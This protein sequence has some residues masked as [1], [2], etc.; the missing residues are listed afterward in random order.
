MAS[1]AQDSTGY[2]QHHLQ[3]LTYGKLPAGFERHDEHGQVHVLEHSEWT[4]A[5]SSEEATAMGFNAIHVDT[6]GWS[7]V[8]G[9][10]FIFIFSRVAAKATIG[11]PTGLQSFVELVVSFVNNTVEDIFHYKNRMIAPMA[12]TIFSWVFMMNLM[13]LI[14]VDWLPVAAAKVTG[15]EHL[16]FKVVPTTDP[17]AT[18][19]MALTV[20]ALMIFFSIKEKGLMGFIK[21]LTLHPFHSGKIY[22]DIFLIP[23]NLILETV[24]LIAKPISLGL[25]LFGNL[26][27]GE[28]IFILIALMFGAGLVLG[29]FGGVL[30]WAWA[31]FHI[32]VI[33]LQAFVFMV[34][35]TVYMAMAHD[36]GENH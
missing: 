9:A 36:T 11:K 18:L 16:F 27:A 17:N 4:F 2:I 15:N 12:L 23:I 29:I 34:L 25:R 35:T 33:T 24:S 5:H 32:L 31:V 30:Q 20:F 6:L 7:I 26:Y 10:L 22:I 28:M 19:G 3:N 13:D 14:P 21:E 1:E 8:L